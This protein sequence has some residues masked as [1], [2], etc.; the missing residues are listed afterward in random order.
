MVLGAPC[1]H[2]CITYSAGAESDIPPSTR[3]VASV[4]KTAWLYCA[5][6]TRIS[7]QQLDPYK[8]RR[9]PRLTDQNYIITSP[10]SDD[11]NCAAWAVEDNE[12]HWWPTLLPDY[13]WP[14]GARR[15]DTLTAI[16]EGYSML[17]YSVCDTSELEPGY[18]KIAIYADGDEPLHVARQLQSGRWTSKL[19]MDWED[20]EH[21]EL[22]DLEC[23]L[24]G[25]PRLFMRKRR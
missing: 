11:Y 22:A 24:Y 17:G 23:D 3:R 5:A 2:R 12:R 13:Y 14:P 16:V 1:D 8:L 4:G 6:G 25:S 21:S 7:M 15:D 20:I 18:E 10:E 19:G 9:Y